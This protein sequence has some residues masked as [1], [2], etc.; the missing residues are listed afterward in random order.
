[1]I[2][3]RQASSSLFGAKCPSVR[4]PLEVF[5]PK[6]DFGCGEVAKATR[7]P[8]ILINHGGNIGGH[9]LG[10]VFT[11]VLTDNF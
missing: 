9:Q 1:M 8:G 2:F 7:Q 5:H 10:V 4:P 6:A 11:K 3:L